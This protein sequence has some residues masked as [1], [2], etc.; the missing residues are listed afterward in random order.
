MAY[1]KMS[2]VL[3]VCVCFRISSEHGLQQD[4]CGVDMCVCVFQDGSEH[5]LQ[6]DEC[7]VDVCVCFRMAHN[8]AYNKMSV[9]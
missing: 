4:E 3:C 5:G 2:V 9:G 1:I 6:Q 8:M 7:G